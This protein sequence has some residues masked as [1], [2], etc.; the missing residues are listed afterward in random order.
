MDPLLP[1]RCSFNQSLMMEYQTVDIG[2]IYLQ[3]NGKLQV[4][5]LETMQDM[6]QKLF[7]SL[8]LTLCPTGKKKKAS[9]V[10]IQKKKNMYL[11]N[12]S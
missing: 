4:P 8:L 5:S 9:R 7:R 2:R 3:E 11:I 1:Q 10:R 6:A 12:Q